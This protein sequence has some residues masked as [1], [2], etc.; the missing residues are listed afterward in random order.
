[1]SAPAIPHVKRAIRE[2]D[3][4]SARELAERALHATS[5]DEVRTLL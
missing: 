3:L 4:T 1:M 2:A 5:A